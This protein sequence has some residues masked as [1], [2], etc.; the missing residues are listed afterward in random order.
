MPAEN[1]LLLPGMMCDARLWAPQIE[2]IGIPA[3]VPALDGA[4]S[5]ASLASQVLDTAPPAFA[6]AGLSMGGILAFEIWRQA[7]DRVTHLAL[8]NTN[9]HPESPERAMQRLEQI[10][11]VLNGGLRDLVRGSLKPL[12]LAACNR[13]DD[14]LL[15]TIMAMTLDLGPEVFQRQT[16]AVKNRPDSVPTLPTI[17][18][19]TVVMC[20]REDTLCPVSYHELMAD[21]IPKAELVV[22]DDCG[23]LASLEQ[24]DRV[25]AELVELFDQ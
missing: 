15:A 2:K 17:S 3:A 9:P 24:P 12:Y 5:I 11:Q 22:L 20:G 16:I 6:L 18:C 1:A 10:E 23:H 4:D 19:P 13:N 8:L 21:R 7:P 14:E 25:T